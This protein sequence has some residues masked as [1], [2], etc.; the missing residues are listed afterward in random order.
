LGGL[1]GALTFAFLFPELE[2]WFLT[3][4]LYGKMTLHESLGIPGILLALP[5]GV[6]C[7]WLAFLSGFQ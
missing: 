2:E 6:V 1:L 7:M 4:G 5:I 3:T